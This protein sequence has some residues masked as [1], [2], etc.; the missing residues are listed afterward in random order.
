MNTR[1]IEL[2]FIQCHL[3]AICLVTM[4]FFPSL[5]FLLLNRRHCEK[6]FYSLCEF[7]FLFSDKK[8]R[9][10]SKVFAAIAF[11]NS[12]SNL[13]IKACVFRDK[14]VK[15][16]GNARQALLSYRGSHVQVPYSRWRTE[17]VWKMHSGL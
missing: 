11:G 13:S 8:L 6:F 9:L 7:S 1:Q 5:F 12:H 15:L 2:R 10:V 14:N 3:C 17:L 4:H 16:R